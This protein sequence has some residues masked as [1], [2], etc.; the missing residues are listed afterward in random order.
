LVDGKTAWPITTRIASAAS[1]P[2]TDATVAIATR[3]EDG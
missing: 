1:D 3:S 2:A